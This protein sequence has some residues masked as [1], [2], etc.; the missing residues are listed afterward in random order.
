MYRSIIIDDEQHAIEGLRSYIGSFPGLELIACYTD[1]PQALRQLHS[2]LPIDVIF[3]DVDM[4]RIYGLELAPQVRN[5]TKKLVFTTAH[6][7][8]Q[9]RLTDRLFG[10]APLDTVLSGG[11]NCSWN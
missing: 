11:T 7:R 8:K 6:A 5:L 10:Y 4:P 2:K 9:L 1:P 3:M